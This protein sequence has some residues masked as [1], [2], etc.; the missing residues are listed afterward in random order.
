[1][2]RVLLQIPA[3]ARR[4]EIIT[5]RTLIQHPMETGFRPGPTGVV[6]PRDILRQ[7]RCT[8]NGAEVF[9][10]ELHPAIAANPY[11]TFTARAEESGTIAFIWTGDNGFSQTETRDIT[12][13]A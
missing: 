5:I 2:A 6:L 10:A 11:L 13:T 9:R 12:V 4:G 8:W 3:T 7:F 1:M